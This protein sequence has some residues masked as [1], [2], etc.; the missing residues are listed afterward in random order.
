MFIIENASIKRSRHLRTFPI[1][2]L[3]WFLL[4][5]YVSIKQFNQLCKLLPHCRPKQINNIPA[6]NWCNYISISDIAA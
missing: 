3:I 6:R 1:M 2:Y 4:Q 5:G